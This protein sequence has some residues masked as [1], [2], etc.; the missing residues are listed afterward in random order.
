VGGHV[1]PWGVATTTTNCQVPFATLATLRTQPS[2][3]DFPSNMRL[4]DGVSAFTITSVVVS[5]TSNPNVPTVTCDVASGLTQFRSYRII[6]QDG[7]I[8][9]I[10]LSAE[11]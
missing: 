11:L 8:G 10:G 7:V 6:G 5:G 4:L 1:S 3:V 2:S 9:Y